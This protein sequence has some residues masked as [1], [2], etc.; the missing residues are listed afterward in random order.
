MTQRLPVA[1][2]IVFVLIGAGCATS[3]HP[4][5][6]PSTNGARSRNG[7]LLARGK[8]AYFAHCVVCHSPDSDDASNGPSMMGYFNRPSTKLSDGTVFPRTDD[9]VR[10]MILKGTENMPPLAQEVTPQE[11]G[12]ILAYLHTL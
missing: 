7:D 9:A 8:K 5:D 4:G 6:A 1:F 3:P 10:G 11:I 12:D 2:A